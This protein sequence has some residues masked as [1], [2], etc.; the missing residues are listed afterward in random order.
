M[1]WVMMVSIACFVYCLHIHSFRIDF[2]FGWLVSVECVFGSVLFE[3][4]IIEGFVMMGMEEFLL[5]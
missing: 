4:V 5:G 3:S 1:H 2:V